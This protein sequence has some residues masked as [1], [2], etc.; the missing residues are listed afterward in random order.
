VSY[1][2][3]IKLQESLVRGRNLV[4]GK[5]PPLSVCPFGVGVMRLVDFG[6]VVAVIA[7][8]SSGERDRYCKINYIHL[9]EVANFRNL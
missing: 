9:V 1:W 4:S 8:C 2:I 3:S 7:L 6:A 5:T